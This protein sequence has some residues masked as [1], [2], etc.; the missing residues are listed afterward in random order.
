MRHLLHRDSRDR[1]FG[2]ST[3]LDKIRGRDKWNSAGYA[4]AASGEIRSKRLKRVEPVLFEALSAEAF[5]TEGIGTEDA[6]PTG[7]FRRAPRWRGPTACR[8]RRRPHDARGS[9]RCGW[10]V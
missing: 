5:G 7:T 1:A 8:T 2:S 10:S 3:N 4:A 6:V 9:S